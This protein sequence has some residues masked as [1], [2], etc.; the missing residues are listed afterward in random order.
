MQVYF[1]TI[2]KTTDGFARFGVECPEVG[3]NGVEN[4]L[5]LAIPPVGHAATGALPTFERVA[6]AP[7]FLARS[8]IQRK[9]LYTGGYPVQHAIDDDGAD[10]HLSG[11][12]GRIPPGDL[13][14]GDVVR[15]NVGQGRI[16][17]A[18]G[19][20]E[21]FGPI[22]TRRFYIGEEEGDK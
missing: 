10:L 1:A 17:V 3:P 4:A 7:D 19:S 6:K 9:G 2:A 11:I 20:A 21:V 8:G 5:V 14:F 13:E 12:G 18:V 16:V 15:A 22:I